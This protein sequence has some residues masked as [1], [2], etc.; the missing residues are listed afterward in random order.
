MKGNG[1]YIIYKYT[2][3]CLLTGSINKFYSHKPVD[4]RALL[5]I[6]PILTMVGGGQIR[7]NLG[8]KRQGKNLLLA[9]GDL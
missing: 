8:I 1:I 7:K 6:N 2:G 4:K 9:T 5:C 3:N